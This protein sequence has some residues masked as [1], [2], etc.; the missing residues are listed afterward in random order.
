MVGYSPVY[1]CRDLHLYPHPSFSLKYFFVWVFPKYDPT[2]I[3]DEIC[4]YAMLFICYS[5]PVVKH[6]E[7]IYQIKESDSLK[8]STKTKHH[9]TSKLSEPEYDVVDIGPKSPD[10]IKLTSNPAYSATVKMED[11]P[12]YS[13]SGNEVVE[14]DYM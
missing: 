4:L 3:T 1:T 9:I 2:S 12:A 14:S 8:D 13:Q 11:N 10:N 7:Q 6:S 5:Y